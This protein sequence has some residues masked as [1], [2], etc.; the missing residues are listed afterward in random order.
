M[1]LTRITNLWAP[2]TDPIEV[3]D[4]EV[5]NGEG[6]VVF[7]E[8]TMSGSGM[9]TAPVTTGVSECDI[10]YRNRRLFEFSGYIPVPR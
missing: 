10:R 5:F 1:N 8:F 4:A 2:F 9:M 7:A 3:Q 6:E